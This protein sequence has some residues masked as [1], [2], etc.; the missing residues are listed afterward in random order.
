MSRSGVRSVPSRA[1]MSAAPLSEKATAASL[2]SP[3]AA[4]TA[5]AAEAGLLVRRPAAGDGDEGAAH[6]CRSRRWCAGFRGRLFGRQR[7][8][9][10]GQDRCVPALPL[11]LLVLYQ[12]VGVLA[13][14]LFPLPSLLFAVDHDWME[15]LR[16]PDWWLR[17]RTD[18]SML[19]QTRY[20][21]LPAS[22]HSPI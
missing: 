8:C 11:S 3:T 22:T 20:D 21:P 7:R 2:M 16:A 14:P 12:L 6:P 10:L 15:W 18:P 19:D 17:L 5:A 13:L 1:T 9:A 4:G